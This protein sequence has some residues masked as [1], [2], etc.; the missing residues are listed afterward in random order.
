MKRETIEKILNFLEEKEDMEKP[1]KWYKVKNQLNLVMTL[2]N[3]PD[4]T[5]YKHYGDL[6]HN[7]SS[8]VKS[9]ITKLPKDLYVTRGFYLNS[10]QQPLELPDKLHVVKDFYMY[11]SNVSELP[12]YLYVGGDLNIKGTPLVEKYTDIEIYKMV[13]LG[14]GEIVGKIIR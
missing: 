11:R 7:V 4:G 10:I 2:K 8:L 14:G 12:K 6:L 5:Q 3:H 13:M 9:S 1:Q